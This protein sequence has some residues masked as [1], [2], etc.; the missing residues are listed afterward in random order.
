M[1]IDDCVDGLADDPR[2]RHARTG[3]PRQFRA[4]L[5]STSSS[6]SSRRSPASS[7]S[8]SYKLDAPQ[9]VR[10]RNSDNTPDPGDLRLG[11][12]DLPRSTGC[13]RPMPGFTTRSSGH[14]A[15]RCAY[16]FTTTAVTPSRC[17]SAASLP[18]AVM[19]STH[20]YCAAYVSGKGHL[21]AEPGE[22]ITFEA[23]GEGVV[24]QKMRFRYRL[25][26]E[27]RFGAQLARQVRRVKP[28]VVLASN[29]PIPTLVPFVMAL[30]VMRTPWVLWHQ[31]VQAIAIRSFAGNQLSRAFRAVAAAIEIG[32]RWCARRAR[33]VVVIADSFVPVHR[34][35]R[36]ED[37]V[38]VIP[39]WAPLD[40]IYPVDRKNDWAVEQQAGRSQDAPLL[41]NSRAQAQPGSAR[42]ARPPS[43][44]RGQPVELVVV[45]EGPA[46]ELLREEAARAGRTREAAAIPALR[47]S[48]GGA[49]HWRHPGRPARGVGGRVLGAVQDALLSVRGSA[50]AGPD[51]KREPR[52][53][54][55]SRELDGCVQP[56]TES[57]LPSGRRAGRSL[58]WA[59][60]N[61]EPR[62]AMRREILPSVSFR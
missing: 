12:F 30:L 16:L 40:E 20:S 10:G 28:D 46:V 39:N 41:R 8:A 21:V 60:R 7:A 36:T 52:G 15:D 45:N 43:H 55:C 62:S 58:C 26:Q 51:A 42:F 53:P 4:G 29:V 22:R 38:S 50:R 33:H 23:I 6:T 25:L 11:T 3:Q 27:L 32:E 47:T 61:D 59:T 54:A 35:W 13:R 24:I 34:A 2:G 49:G 44:R 1:Y 5:R 56:P 9:G 48:A 31:D 57:S 14:R 18:A 37:K 17:N 19:T